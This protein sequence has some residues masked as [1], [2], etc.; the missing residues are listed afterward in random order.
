VS[1]KESLSLEVLG[2]VAV[3][4]DGCRREIALEEDRIFCLQCGH[5]ICRDCDACSGHEKVSYPGFREE[6]DLTR[7]LAKASDFLDE[8]CGTN[9]F[10]TDSNIYL[11]NLRLLFKLVTAK[12][13]QSST[14][15]AKS[16]VPAH[17]NEWFLE[18]GEPFLRRWVSLRGQGR[19][20]D[21]FE[22]RAFA[23]RLPSSA[24]FYQS[25]GAYGPIVWHGKPM[26][27][28]V[29]DF[30]LSAIMLQELR[31]KTII[32]L[33]TASG[34]S[35]MWYADLQ[36]LHGLEPRV[37]TFDIDPPSLSYHGVTI[38]KGDSNEIADAL[39]VEELR[40]HPHPWLVVEDAHVNI[41]GVLAHFDLAM[42]KGDYFI[43]EDIDSERELGR[44][45]LDRPNRYKVDARYTDFFGHNATCAPDQILRRMA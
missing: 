19:F 30:A 22:R 36:Q 41:G 42:L 40:A 24:T 45:L 7:L 8:S 33:G 31:P 25:Q 9:L 14:Q 38:V 18:H 37:I 1:R 5:D 2:A 10:P 4:C 13:D 16:K 3:F 34:A 39:P 27:R 21:Y 11:A 32:E 29:W 26:I 35:A 17:I 12:H 44:F 28:T 43:I 6:S 23:G 15:P 20:V